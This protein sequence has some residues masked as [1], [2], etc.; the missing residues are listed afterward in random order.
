MY[1]ALYSGPGMLNLLIAGGADVKLR[2][3]NGLTALGWAAHS[4][5]SA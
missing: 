3:K 1:A 5:E 2:D 4:K